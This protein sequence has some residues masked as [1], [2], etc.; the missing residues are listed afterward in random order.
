MV[1][2]AAVHEP[3]TPGIAAM[4]QA[5]LALPVAQ[6]GSTCVL[7]TVN[8]V[9]PGGEMLCAGCARQVAAQ[10]IAEDT[11]E[12]ILAVCG[13]EADPAARWPRPRSV[14]TWRGKHKCS[15]SQRRRVPARR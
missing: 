4:R 14:P 3:L 12:K 5:L 10:P 9:R 8:P 7:C 1:R 11:R 13:V 2:D 6:E 15:K